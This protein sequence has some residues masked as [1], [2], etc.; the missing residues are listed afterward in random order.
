MCHHGHLPTT[1]LACVASISVGLG[2][3]ERGGATNRMFGVLPAQKW[4]E[5]QNKK[6]GVGEGKLFFA[7]E[8]HGNACYAGYNWVCIYTVHVQWNPDFLNPQ[9]LKHPE[10]SSQNC[11]QFCCLWKFFKLGIPL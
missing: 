4:G 7:P 1:G 11:C 2:S 8:P 5:S 10:N 6:Q 9:L 3:K